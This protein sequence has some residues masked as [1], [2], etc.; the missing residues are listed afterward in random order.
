MIKTVFIMLA[1]SKISYLFPPKD[2][3]HYAKTAETDIRKRHLPRHATRYPLGLW[4]LLPSGR[5]KMNE[6]WGL[7]VSPR[8]WMV[9]CVVL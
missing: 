6:D 9:G 3:N 8:M 7:G 1:I 2:K 5:K 4:I